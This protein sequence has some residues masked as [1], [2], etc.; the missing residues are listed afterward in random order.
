MLSEQPRTSSFSGN[1]GN[2]VEVAFTGGVVVV[3]DTKDR[4]KPAHE[5]TRAE[6]EAFLLG[7][8]AGEF[9]LPA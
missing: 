6:W 8:K 4:D 3:T 2:C 9:D 7:A 1:N 5:F